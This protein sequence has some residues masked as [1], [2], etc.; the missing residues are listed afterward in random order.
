MKDVNLIPQQPDMLEALK[1]ASSRFSNT[2]GEATAL[3][4]LQVAS[5]YAGLGV[6][7]CFQPA[8]TA[9]V[10]GEFIN[11]ITV[12]IDTGK[13]RREKLNTYSANQTLL[14]VLNIIEKDN[15]EE[16]KLQA[17]KRLFLLSL[18]DQP[19]GEDA[20]L[21]KYFIA[22]CARM[23]LE[24]LLLLRA[25]YEM[26]GNPVNMQKVNQNLF[27]WRQEVAIVLRHGLTDYVERAEIFLIEEKLLARGSEQSGSWQSGREG[28]KRLTK[29]GFKFCNFILS[30]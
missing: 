14:Q 3:Q 28:G 27:S 11:D 5:K 16:E 9:I 29:S 21:A 15:L 19:E 23:P 6:A 7:A 26:E 13:I 22:I 8:M 18:Q 24:S 10:V 4:S 12:A 25:A 30:I 1:N 20:G 2:I 17:I